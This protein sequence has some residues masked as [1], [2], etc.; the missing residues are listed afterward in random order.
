MEVEEWIEEFEMYNRRVQQKPSADEVEVVY[1]CGLP[2]MLGG[3]MEPDS[4]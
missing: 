2:Q 4:F 3:Y 1:L